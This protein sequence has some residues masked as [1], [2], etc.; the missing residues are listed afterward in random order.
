MPATLASTAG[1][2]AATRFKP[3]AFGDEG[4][5]RES[6]YVGMEFSDAVDKDRASDAVAA[7]ERYLETRREDLGL[8]DI[9]SYFTAD[10]AGISLFFADGVVSDRFFRPAR[11]RTSRS[12]CPSRP[13]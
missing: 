13:A 12:T 9:Y 11:A 8:R 6:L 2:M 10:Q 3:E 1:L 5:R 7:A 4:V